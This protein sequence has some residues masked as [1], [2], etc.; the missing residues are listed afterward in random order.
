MAPFATHSACL[1]FARLDA[2]VLELLD[3]LELLEAANELAALN[4]SAIPAKAAHNPASFR[5][6]TPLDGPWK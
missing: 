4:D 6:C 5:R 1:S 2:L 3:E